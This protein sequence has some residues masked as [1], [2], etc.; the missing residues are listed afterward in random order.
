MENA[1]DSAEIFLSVPCPGDWPA[2][3]HHPIPAVLE[4]A[5]DQRL[6][7]LETNL[8]VPPPG[9][10][11]RDQTWARIRIGLRDAEIRRLPGFLRAVKQRIGKNRWMLPCDVLV[12]TTSGSG[13]RVIVQAHGPRTGPG[14]APDG[15]RLVRASDM[16]VVAPVTRIAGR[17]LASPSQADWRV[18]ALCA[19][20]QAGIDADILGSL[21]RRWPGMRLA[22][23]D[24]AVLHGMTVM[25]IVAHQPD[26]R[27]GRQDEMDA[28]TQQYADAHATILVDEWQTAEQLG[29]GQPEPLL[30]VNIRG[31]D[32]PG[33]ILDT[34]ESLYATLSESLPAQG[35]PADQTGSPPA[36]AGQSGQ[37]GQPGPP[38]QSIGVWHALT[39][40]T[41]ISTSRLVIRLATAPDVVEGWDRA[42][43]EEIER[44]TRQRAISAARRR[45][46]SSLTGDRFGIAED[47]L[48][49]VGLLQSLRGTL[50]TPANGDRSGP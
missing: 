36:Q 29:Q 10:E 1:P 15:S 8:P 49:S 3:A 41:A 35:R 9:A 48:I 34:L 47:T 42:K 30:R 26:G 24:H 6:I 31:P 17:G 13:L 11:Y 38:N 21:G 45:Q 40:V 46:A 22:G 12:R 5:A 39:R 2:L 23:L 44:E 33:M 37:S 28:L 7:V 20:A 50:V 16:D 14:T 18:L 43:F 27:S 25:L 19:D 32:Q 4:A